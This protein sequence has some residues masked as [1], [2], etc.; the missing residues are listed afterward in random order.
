MLSKKVPI[1]R[2]LFP[3]LRLLL[4]LLVLYNIIACGCGKSHKHN[5]NNKGEPNQDIASTNQD[6][7]R[8]LNMEV[9]PIRLDGNNKQ[10]TATFILTDN[11][12][13]VDLKQ[14]K[15][16]V[17][18]VESGSTIN[19][20]DGSNTLRIITD[21]V[22]KNLTHF[23]S[24]AE[25]KPNEAPLKL[26]FDIV[27]ST[28]ATSVSIVFKLFDKDSAKLKE[29]PISWNK[30]AARSG[31]LKINKLAYEQANSR[32]VCSI[33]N[34][35]KELVKD[36]QLRYTN[37]SQ[38]TI[39]KTVV[40]DNQQVGVVNFTSIAPQGLTEDQILPIDFKSAIKAT[41]RFEV[42]H[43]GKVV[44]NAVEE[45]EFDYKE[46]LLKLVAVGPTSLIGKDKT[47]RLR[48]EKEASSSNIDVSKLELRLI[49]HTTSDAYLDYNGKASIVVPGSELNITG[50]NIILVIQP[51]TAV[52][53]SFEL[54][55]VYAP[56]VLDKQPF[57]WRMDGA[58]AN[59][60]LL[61][62]AAAGN[63]KKIEELLQ[64]PEI[65]INIKNENEETPLH[66][67]AKSN[68]SAVIK[69]LLDQ[70]NIQVNHKD[71]QGYTPLSIAVEQ[72][73]R[74]ATLALL[75]V[76]GI[77]INTKNKWGNS[78]LHLA[79]QK[80]NQE[81]VEDLIAKGA[82]VNATNNYGITPL[83]IAT[84]VAN[85]RNVALLLAEGANINR[86]DEKGNTSLHIAVEKGKE[87]V[88]ELLLATRA[89]VKMIDKRGLTP[90]HKAALA[91]N[92]LAIQAL[93][94][95]K[96]EVNAEDMHG[97]TPLHKAVE[98]GDK[99]AIQAL[100]AVKEIKL[101]A[102]D[103]DGNTPLHIAVLKGNEE[104]VTALL[105]KGVKV[106]VKD[107]YN[108][109]P[110]HIAAQKGNVSIIKKLIKK[111]EGINAKD[112]MGYTPLHM[113][114]YYDHPAIVE[115]LL[116]KQARRDIKDAQGETVVDLV[117]RSTNEEIKRLFAK[118]REGLNDKDAMGYT[119]ATYH[120]HPA[121]DKLLP[122]KQADRN[123]KD[124]QEETEVDLV[125]RSVNEEMEGLFGITT[126]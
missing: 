124:E 99:E 86:M 27:P 15:L 23:F 17:K 36:V 64:I 42:L 33:Q 62:A 1:K 115:L 48:I 9:F 100:L 57:T 60:M 110:L 71:K 95:R 85:T 126:P 43:Q 55:L 34:N 113:A 66:E 4:S 74:L 83:H 19:Y 41:F 91:S 10:V 22:E 114:I 90:L 61:E 65:D 108:N 82:N 13:V 105:D 2:S 123:I 107:K 125:W 84:K 18:L 46:A 103:N 37:I 87:Q 58:Q 112:A 29:Y 28:E 104:A 49:Q 6:R 8:R 54:H 98:K 56:R 53:A 52:Q 73:S 39:G 26:S 116:K 21:K 97:N 35:S 51:S 40:L 63:E 59:K 117:R 118:N 7:D 93:L 47:I 30:E 77:D 24:I 44:E 16:R 11:D 14:Y 88:L 72:N 81:L 5:K 96:A 111:R 76:E 50:D 121:I 94:A 12:K 89:N 75:Q 120:D 106:N 70:E 45:K 20:K 109:M 32:V 3:F 68:N 38:D 122:K 92:K 69:L 31:G 80:D 79:I 67:A 102:K 78:P 25:L 101:Y 119:P